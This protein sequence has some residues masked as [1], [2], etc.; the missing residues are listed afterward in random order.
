MGSVK[1]KK[2]KG[3]KDIRDEGGKPGAGGGMESKGRRVLSWRM[4]QAVR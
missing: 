2:S 4:S 3:G 1:G